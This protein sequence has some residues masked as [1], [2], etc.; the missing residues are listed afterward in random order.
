MLSV[1]D[2][3]PKGSGHH[4]RQRQ[5]MHQLDNL[6]NFVHE[7][8]EQVHHG[9]KERSR[10]MNIKFVGIPIILSLAVGGVGIILFKGVS[11]R[12]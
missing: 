10:L 2:S 7:N 5:L 3:P 4:P 12:N 1:E 9:R 6:S 11:S 8:I